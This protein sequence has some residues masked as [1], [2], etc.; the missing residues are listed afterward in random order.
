ML[1]HRVINHYFA[2]TKI[3]W[4]VAIVLALLLAGVG[5][6][7]Y[8]MMSNQAAPVAETP[9]LMPPVDESGMPAQDATASVEVTAGAQ[10]T[11]T[12]TYT[13][14]GFA[15]AKVFIKNGDAVQF[16]NK[17]THTMWVGV[18]DHP[19]HTKYDGTSTKE[20]CAAGKNLNG[21]FD[22]CVGSSPGTTYTYTFTKTGTF[23]YHNHTASKDGGSVVVE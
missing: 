13:D 3:G 17:S 14:A 2:M 21:S 1:R 5:A 12:V 23:D 10:T 19:S 8:F 4:I 7:V 6:G 15:P 11:T 18:D 9:T 16:V 22:Q 20:H